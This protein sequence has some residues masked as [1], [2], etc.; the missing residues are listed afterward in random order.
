MTDLT[1]I[2]ILIKTI[3]KHINNPT[4]IGCLNLPIDVTTAIDQSVFGICISSV[5]S[6][7]N[8]MYHEQ[9]LMV[10][11]VGFENARFLLFRIM[12]AGCL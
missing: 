3:S 12:S 5:D 4:C 7:D 11:S 8:A 6:L 10:A 2:S 1:S 9:R